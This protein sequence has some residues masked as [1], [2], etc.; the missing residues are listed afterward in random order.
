MIELGALF[1]RHDTLWWAS[2]VVALLAGVF[3]LAR[4][5]ERRALRATWVLLVFGL[6][7]HAGTALA[8]ANPLLAQ[9]LLGAAVVLLGLAAIQVGAVLVF[10]G[11]MP[12]VGLNTPRIAQDLSVTGLSIAWGL[13]WLRLSGVDPSQLFTTSAI[14]TAVVAFS[15]QDTLGNVLGGVALQLDSSLRV[16][17]WVKLDDISGRVVD[18][19]WRYT[20][21][22]TRSRELVIVPNSW[23]MKNRFTVI[24]ARGDE[25]LAWRRALDFQVDAAADPAAVIQ[26]LEHAVLDAEIPGVLSDPAPS[27][28]LGE[29]AAGFGRYTLR[30]WLGDPGRDDPCDSAVRLHALAAL[31]RAGLRLGVPLEERLMIKENA[32]WHA[33]AE[34]RE[35]DR[36]LAAIRQTALFARLP[37]AEQRELASHLVHAPFAAGGTITRQGAVAHWLYLIIRGE[38][39]VLVD[40]PRGRVPVA[41]LHDGDFFGE[42]GMLTGAPRHATVV[43]VTAVDCYRLD[44]QGFARV[45]QARPEVALEM[46]AIVEARNAELGAN[47]GKP[48]GDAG[49][50]G[51][52]LTRIRHFFSLGS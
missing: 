31:E 36:R 15:M 14:I 46:S 23:L 13:L 35:A 18:V 44:K 9:T 29:V 41:T 40:G 11:L 10:R 27:A 20:A 47:L 45:I 52:L 6:A 8:T 42:M 49:A 2:L 24:R 32:S 17:D 34:Q 22:E 38:V 4:P 28:I 43:A 48:A 21:I 33:A 16:G 25:P 5:A 26:S 39:Q 3:R 30:Y 19:R 7:S 1:S 51:D 12:I 37:E 50:S